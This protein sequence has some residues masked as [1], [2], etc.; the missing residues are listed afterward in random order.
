MTHT[1]TLTDID[2]RA[3]FK[4]IESTLVAY[5]ASRAGNNGGRPLVLEVRD[6][7]GAVIGGLWGYTSYG[8]L[9]I[10]L[11]VLPASLRGQGIGSGMLLAAE[12]EAR[13]RG[14][15]GAW[16]DTFEFQARA[17][18]EK[19]GYACFGELPDYPRG[20]ARYFMQKTLAGGS[21]LNSGR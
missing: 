16:L 8:W 18:Y 14:C 13:A 12:T 10:E 11:F 5:N 6:E 3:V 1:I 2:D 19:F 15:H 9:F 17:F 7:S 21:A 4:A 20:H